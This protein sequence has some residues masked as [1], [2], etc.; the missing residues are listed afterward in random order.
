ATYVILLALAFRGTAAVLGR[1]R[2]RAALRAPAHPTFTRFAVPFGGS[3][4]MNAILQRASIFIL[5]AFAGAPTVA[6]FAAADELGRAVGAARL[7]FDSI[8]TPMMSEAMRLRDQDRVRYLLALMTRWVASASAPLAVTLF[9]LRPQLLA[10]YGPHY[11][12]AATAMGFL[13][14]T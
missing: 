6:L 13:L 3:E 9:V 7:A 10:L 14:L 4:L 5:T 2:L 1:R 12:D 11:Q 8:I